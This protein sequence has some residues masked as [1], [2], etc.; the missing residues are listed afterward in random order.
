VSLQWR[1]MGILVVHG[2]NVTI[3]W[4]DSRQ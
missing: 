1:A 2:W 4:Y 3:S